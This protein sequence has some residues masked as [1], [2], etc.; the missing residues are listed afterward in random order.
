MV[1]GYEIS[2]NHR[3]EKTLSEAQGKT[4]PDFPKLFVKNSCKFVF[5]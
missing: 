3:R 2:I 1:Y 5:T 4:I